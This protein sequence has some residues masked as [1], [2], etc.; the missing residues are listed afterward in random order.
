MKMSEIKT[1]D[2]ESIKSKVEELKRELFNLRFNIHTTGIEKPHL[3]K[4]AKKNIARLL[5]QL[6]V[7]KAGK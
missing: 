6:N 5:T 1:M 7:L 2:V 4:D 3:I